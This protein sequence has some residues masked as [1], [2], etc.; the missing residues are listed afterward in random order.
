[1]TTRCGGPPT[2]DARRARDKGRGL[3]RQPSEVVKRWDRRPAAAQLAESRRRSFG[4]S[5]PAVS[6]SLWPESACHPKRRQNRI[7][8]RGSGCRRRSRE[9]RFRP[10]FEQL[11]DRRL[12][13][14]QPSSA[15]ASPTYIRY[16]PAGSAPA[17]SGSNVP[18]GLTPA[19]VRAAYG[20]SQVTFS[21]GAIV[22]NGAG[23][24]IALVDAFDDPNIVGDLHAFDAAFGL[25]DPPNFTRVAQ[26]GSTNYPGTDPS[27][28]PGAGADTWE[29]ETALDVEWSHALA[30]GANIL[31][32]EANSARQFGPRHGDRLRQKRAGRGRGVD[33][34]LRPRGSQRKRHRRDDVRP[35]RR[36]AWRRHFSRCHWRQRRQWPKF[37]QRPHGLSS[38]FAERRR[39]RRHDA[40]D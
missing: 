32:V 10:V 13:S 21:N 27:G 14:A 26:D 2:R 16:A 40:D 12:L 34:L 20:F 33:E 3:V 35:A 28:S 7:G 19:Q 38:L 39:G 31:L 5:S 22:G 37:P 23:Q 8:P 11:E 18:V 24:T 25:P 30:P 15:I 29:V 9:L 6:Q 36:I 4:A 1:M 17:E